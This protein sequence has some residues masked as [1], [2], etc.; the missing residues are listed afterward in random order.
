VL[1]RL[2]LLPIPMC[3]LLSRLV[4]VCERESERE[5]AREREI[6]RVLRVWCH[7]T[8]P[9]DMV[10]SVACCMCALMAVTRIDVHS[11]NPQ[12]P[13]DWFVCV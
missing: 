10:C 13:C 6:V 8:K 9:W 2:L 7:I 11:S 4:C 1:G 12:A 5:S 3:R